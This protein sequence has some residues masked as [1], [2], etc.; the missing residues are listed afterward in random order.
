MNAIVDRLNKEHRN[1]ARY[2]SIIKLIEQRNSMIFLIWN[3][4]IFSTC[5]ISHSSEYQSKMNIVTSFTDY[6]LMLNVS[7]SLWMCSSKRGNL[8]NLTSQLNHPSE[9][10]GLSS[11]K[12]QT[13]PDFRETRERNPLFFKTRL[14]NIRS[15]DLNSFE[16]PLFHSYDTILRTN[17]R[18]TND[19]RI[20]NLC[21]SSV[22]VWKKYATQ[23]E[24]ESQLKNCQTIKSLSIPE[25]K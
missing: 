14:S 17:V 15:L 12:T 23:E 3:N 22:L 11:S 21:E 20:K 10:F 9:L 16:I 18:A 1:A 7:F 8:A 6:S 4:L 19:Q 25:N 13:A 24:K 5:S 2:R